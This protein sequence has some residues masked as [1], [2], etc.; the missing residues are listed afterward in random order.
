MAASSGFAWRSTGEYRTASNVR[1]FM[2]RHGIPNYEA[3]IARANGDVA[4]FWPA[5][6]GDLGVAWYRPF[7]RLMDDSRGIAWTRWFLGG[8]TNIV[9]NCLDR[10]ATG[11]RARRPAVVWEGEDGTTRTVTYAALAAD[12]DRCAAGLSALGVGLGDRVGLYLPMSPEAV[13][14]LFA[15]LKLGA[16]AVPTF[17]GFGAE[18]LATRLADAQAKVLFT[19]NAGRRRARTLAIKAEADRAATMVP[20]LRHLVVARRTDADAPWT[21]GRDVWFDDLLRDAHGPIATASLDAET[22]AMILYTSGTTGRPKG[23]I[24]THAGCL[25]QIAKEVAYYFDLRPDDR[26]FWLTDIGWVMGAWEVIGT[27]FFGA[28]AVLYDGAP[29]FPDPD[30]LLALVE[31]HRPTHFGISPTAVRMLMRVDDAV[32]ARRDLSSLRILASSGEPWDPESW[33]WFFERV[34]KRR[35]PIINFSGGTEL[36]G[37]LVS[38]LPI[39][40]LK[41]CTVGGPGLGMDVDI[42]D[43]AGKSVREGI[44]H[45]VCRKPAPSMTKG[46]LGDPERYLETYF[47]RWPD[48]WDHGDW[49]SR[50]ADGQWFLHGRSDDTMKIAGKR[51]GPAEVEAALI[52][53]AAVSEAAAIG[54]PD[55]LKGEAIVCFV[56]LRAGIVFD[57]ALRAALADGVVAALGKTH[58]PAAVHAVDALPKTRSGKILR[59]AIRRRYLGQDPGDLSSAEDPELLAAI[60]APATTAPSS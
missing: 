19:A 26:L 25:A 24:A 47:G 39:M 36:M 7:D 55:A 35:L 40:D 49:A 2:D 42:V 20:T 11:P 14:A 5:A 12:V 9:L 56:V 48:I 53:H 54:V 27:T 29:D 46:F 60:P 52:A 50:D 57:D 30:R 15:C 18:A 21:P 38:P 3:L 51:T 22:W 43:E 1:R 45:L 59:G 4:W 33:A 44:G 28:T 8:R 23:T 16:V 17:S 32:V 31:R 58:R 6:L 37:G 10:H 41:P 13:V 34:G